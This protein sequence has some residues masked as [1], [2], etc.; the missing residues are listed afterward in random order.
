MVRLLDAPWFVMSADVFHAMMSAPAMGPNRLEGVPRRP[1]RGFQRAV[2]GMAADGPPL[3]SRPGDSPAPSRVHAHG[4]DDVV[5]DSGDRS[6][7]GRAREIEAFLRRPSA[8][9]TAF[10]RMKAA[11]TWEQGP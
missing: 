9:P 2:A 4:D 8:G 11:G 6:P 10:A 7:Q 5:V 1:W 3:P